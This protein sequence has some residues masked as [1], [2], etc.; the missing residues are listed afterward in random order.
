MKAN[1]LESH[2]RLL[3]LHKK[4][5]IIEKGCQDCIDNRP[6]EF[7]DHP[8]YIFAHKRTFHF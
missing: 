6:A 2:D 3:E 8:F 5:D 1:K 7:E 4:K